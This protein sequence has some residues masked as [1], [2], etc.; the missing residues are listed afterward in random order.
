MIRDVSERR[1]ADETLR[2]SERSLA[3][4]QQVGVVGSWEWDVGGRPTDVV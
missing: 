2:E 4:A 3:R 1:Q